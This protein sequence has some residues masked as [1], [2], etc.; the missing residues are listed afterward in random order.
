MVILSHGTTV[1]TSDNRFSVIVMMVVVISIIII[2][3]KN[4]HQL[5]SVIGMFL[6]MRWKKTLLILAEIGIV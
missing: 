6:M 2:M 3:M 5:I 1:F 4:G